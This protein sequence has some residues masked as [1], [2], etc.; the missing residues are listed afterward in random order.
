MNRN[1]Y[2]AGDC[3]VCS[4]S[5]ALIVLR[6]RGR[7]ALVFFCPLCEVTWSEPP[8]SMAVEDI[9]KLS[10]LA[11]RGV[12]LPSRH[13]LRWLRACGVRISR[14]PF[15]EWGRFLESILA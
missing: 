11:P 7:F 1:L 15:D 8:E 14:V 6:A 9:Q 12:A 4:D 2:S 10:D 13:D 3:A 5:G